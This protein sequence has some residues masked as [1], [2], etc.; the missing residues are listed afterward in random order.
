MAVELVWRI[1][2]KKNLSVYLVT[3]R[4]KVL[5]DGAYR[6]WETTILSRKQRLQVRGYLID[7]IAA[8]Y[9]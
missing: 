4:C 9:L 7:W 2:I 6:K 1:E 5:S 3:L 8:L